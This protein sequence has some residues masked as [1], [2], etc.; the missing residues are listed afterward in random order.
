MVLI[1][2]FDITYKILKN[3]N[4][5]LRCLMERATLDPKE[6]NLREEELVKIQLFSNQNVDQRFGQ[7]YAFPG[8]YLLLSPDQSLFLCLPFLSLSDTCDECS[9]PTT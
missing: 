5:K 7:V 9:T 6:R 3:S 4:R 2:V 8:S 1:I